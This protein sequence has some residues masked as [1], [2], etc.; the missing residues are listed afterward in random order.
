MPSRRALS[1]TCALGFAPASFAVLL[2][3]AHPASAAESCSVSVIQSMVPPGVTIASANSVPAGGDAPSYCAVIG[4]LQTQGEGEPP[5]SAGFEFRLPASWNRKFLFLGVGGLAGATYAD[6]SANRVD[7]NGA[8]TKGYVTAVTDSG[9]LAGRTDAAWALIAPG[10]PDRAK[11]IDYYSRATHQVT[12]TGKALSAAFYGTGPVRSYF[13]GCSN[14]GRQALV[15]ATRY[16]HD[17]DGV[18]AGDPF[19]DT[20]YMI[21]AAR[22]DKQMLTPQSYVPASLLPMVDAAVAASCRDVDGVDDGLI[23]NPAACPLTSERLACRPGQTTACLSGA[24]VAT[25]TAYFSPIRTPDGVAIYP[26]YS[27]SDL[28]GVPTGELKLAGAERWTFGV[29]PPLDFSAPEPWGGAGFKPAP[30]GYQ[31]ADHVLKDIVMRDP[32]YDLRDFQVGADG[33]VRAATLATYDA[34]TRAGSA[35]DAHDYQAFLGSGRKM[36]LYHG[37]SDPALTP[38]RTIQLYEQ[39]AAM[40]GGYNKVQGSARLFMV[41]GMHHCEGGPGPNSFDT[42]SALEDW[43]ERGRAP[44][45]IMA[46]HHVDDDLKAPVNRSMPLCPF[47]TQA[48]FDGRGDVYKAAGWSCRPNRKLL[49]TSGAGLAAGLK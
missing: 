45:V 46:H 22:I 17:Y 41:P 10:K 11:L 48:S 27:V 23:Q 29:T 43:V 40:A 14:G 4:R 37:F 12:I 13:D 47:P 32:A 19:L 1:H 42:L 15:E 21:A 18:I 30:N 36:I 5:G 20:R 26:G 34:A 49:Q 28:S 33:V 31:F 2:L 3:G 39:L 7:V 24:Q 25:L 35:T 38:Y 44:D 9:H 8:L 16:P 6:L